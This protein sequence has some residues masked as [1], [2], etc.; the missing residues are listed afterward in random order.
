MD[1]KKFLNSMS[2][3]SAT[4]IIIHSMYLGKIDFKSQLVTIGQLIDK[5]E[6]ELPASF[7]STKSKYKPEIKKY[8][9]I[10]NNIYINDIS[11]TS[12]LDNSN[13]KYI[14]VLVTLTK[15]KSVSILI[16]IE[17]YIVIKAPKTLTKAKINELIAEKSKWIISKIKLN[18]TKQQNKREISN[19]ENGKLVYMGQVCDIHFGSQSNYVLEYREGVFYTPFKSPDEIRSF[20]IEWYKQN[21]KYYL[22]NRT[23]FI[24]SKYNFRYKSVKINSATS[25]WGSCS[26]DNSINYSWKLLQAPPEVIDYVV[27]HEL[28]HTIIKDH[29]SK[30]W[31][32]VGKI[33]PDYPNAV[34]WLKDNNHL[35]H[36]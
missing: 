32:T 34:K 14:P 12:N 3:K 28:V 23:A 4:F 26:S 35:I 9:E 6:E 11:E 20:V 27:I 36:F 24:A 19:L 31:A 8:F 13:I 7:E 16:P 29:S 1:F 30:F 2:K 10:I 5:Y 17:G 15:R 21:A 25:R 22:K 33:Y 18:E